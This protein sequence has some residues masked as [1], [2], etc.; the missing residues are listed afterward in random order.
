MSSLKRTPLNRRRI[1]V[2]TKEMAALYR[3]GLELRDQRGERARDEFIQIH[4]RLNWTLLGRDPHM[5]SVFEDLDGEPPAYMRARNS[6]AYPD[7]NGWYSGAGIGAFA[8]IW[9]IADDDRVGG[10]GV[11]RRSRVVGQIE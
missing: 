9:R 3:R 8:P 4:K 2:I 1:L 11:V 6:M 10:D 5:V 7:F